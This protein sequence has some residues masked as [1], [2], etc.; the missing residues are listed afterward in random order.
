MYALLPAARGRGIATSVLLRLRDWA[1]THDRSTVTLVTVEGNAASAAVAH[2]AGF[3]L[4]EV[5][6]GQ[7]RGVTATLQR[8]RFQVAESASS[9]G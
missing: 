3:S 4:V 7:H 6:E 1:A 9:A 2:R 8:W 5:Y